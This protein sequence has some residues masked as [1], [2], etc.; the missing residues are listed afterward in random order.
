ML[1][2]LALRLLFLGLPVVLLGCVLGTL[3][4]VLGGL[5][6]AAVLLLM[7]LGLLGIVLCLRLL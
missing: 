5:D 7:L 1:M 2:G 6:R 4:C 3:L